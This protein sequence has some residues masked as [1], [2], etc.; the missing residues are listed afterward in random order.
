MFPSTVSF[1]SLPL[2]KARTLAVLQHVREYECPIHHQEWSSHCPLQ[3]AGD[4]APKFNLGLHII[5]G[6]KEYLSWVSQ[7]TDSNVEQDPYRGK[8]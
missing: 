8:E 5:P 3:P 2:V 4:P 6:I 7:E 1:A